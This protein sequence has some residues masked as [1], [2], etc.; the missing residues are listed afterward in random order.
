M[1]TDC[2]RCGSRNPEAARYCGRCGLVLPTGGQDP[3]PGRAPH[4]QP[5]AAPPGFAAVDGACDLYYA[6]TGPGG[7]ARIL[8]TEGFELRVFN[9]GYPLTAVALRVTGR[10]AAGAVALSVEREVAALPRGATAGVEIASW[11]V[12]EPVRSLSLALVSAAYG[13]AEE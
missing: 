6:W 11:E 5:L 10:T 13:D 7:A 9:A 4:P 2:V 8:G 3:T 12:G 1:S